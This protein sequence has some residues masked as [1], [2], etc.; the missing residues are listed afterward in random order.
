L[1]IKSGEV[2]DSDRH[3]ACLHHSIHRQLTG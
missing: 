2:I 3:K 1:E